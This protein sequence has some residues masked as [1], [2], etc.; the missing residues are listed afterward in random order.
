MEVA[1]QYLAGGGGKSISIGADD[2]LWVGGPNLFQWDEGSQKWIEKTPFRESIA[3]AVTPDGR[4]WVLTPG[5]EDQANNIFEWDGTSWQPRG[6]WGFHIAIGANGT[7]CHVGH[8]GAIYQYAGN[9]RWTVVPDVYVPTSDDVWTVGPHRIAVDPD[10]GCW[11]IGRENEIYRPS[12]GGWQGMGAWAQALAIGL[13]GE[14]IHVGHGNAIFILKNGWVCPYGDAWA[15]DVTI[16]SKG[17]CVHIGRGRNIYR[18]VI[19]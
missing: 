11:H 2:G 12:R 16:D 9:N 4:P 8:G 17:R 13:H 15:T 6:G 1:W 18:Q 3:V 7:V 10:G 19:P 14:V 5:D